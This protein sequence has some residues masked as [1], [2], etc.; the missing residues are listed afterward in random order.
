MGSLRSMATRWTLMVGLALGAGMACQP[1]MP[2]GGG[3]VP[4]CD[5]LAAGDFQCA[6]GGRTYLL[7]VPQRLSSPAPLVVDS[8]GLGGSAM[9]Q[10]GLS[11]WLQL[12]DQRGFVVIHPQ[13]ANN[14]FNGTGG[15]C[16]FQGAMDDVGL[17]RMIVA[18]TVAA[19]GGRID[20]QRVIATGFSNG[21]AIT[22]R[23]GC[24]A[25]DVFTALAPVAFS[26]GGPG[27]PGNT[28]QVAA[29]CRPAKP[30]T[31]LQTHG[32]ADT[33]ADF[34]NG[35]LQSL[36]A[37]QSLIAWTMVNRCT[38]APGTMFSVPTNVSC[39]LR[40]AG[41]A[42]GSQ[43]ALCRVQ[44]SGHN[45]YPPVRQATGMSIPEII[46]PRL[47]TAIA[48]QIAAGNSR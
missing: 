44:G 22:H 3:G 36:P 28:A 15:C 10:R 41:C 33:V 7:H 20:L 47:L 40:T 17:F 21:G 37:P 43:V 48:A 16:A 24:E 39:E 34:N 35:V 11:G 6:I 26:L 27:G 32:T 31:M 19:G 46:Y 30:I 12:S 42:G 1:M 18:R 4:G 14:S 23:L 9:G 8:H 5:D 25:A 2:G 29:A 45:A 13:G 38:N